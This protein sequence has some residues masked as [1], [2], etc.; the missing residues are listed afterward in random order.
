MHASSQ[1][2]VMAMARSSGGRIRVRPRFFVILGVLFLSAYLLYGYV[3]G[4]VRMGAMRAEL[5]RV[6]AEIARYEALNA[7]LRAELEHYNSDAYIERVAREELGLVKPG[8]TPVMLIE[9]P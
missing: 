5:E 7:Q 3:D 9:E 2:G 4:F 6:R 1:P 8:E